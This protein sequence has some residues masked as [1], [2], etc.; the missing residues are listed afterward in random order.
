MHPRHQNEKQKTPP[1]AGE[2]KATG[3]LKVGELKVTRTVTRTFIWDA[4]EAAVLQRRRRRGGNRTARKAT[5]RVSR[6]APDE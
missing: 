2:L 4:D 5:A 6:A 1:R 3:E